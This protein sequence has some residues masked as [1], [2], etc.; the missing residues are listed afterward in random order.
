MGLLNCIRIWHDNTGQG[1]SAGWFLKSIIIRDLQTMEKFYF[2]AQ[3]WF[4]LEKDDGKVCFVLSFR[5]SKF[6][7]EDR[8]NQGDS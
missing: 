8:K 6:L 7:K 5:L 3:K 4:A 2:I 1:S